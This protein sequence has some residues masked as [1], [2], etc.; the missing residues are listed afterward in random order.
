[1]LES[2]MDIREKS[3]VLRESYVFGTLGRIRTDICLSTADFKSAAATN[4]ATRVLN[5]KIIFGRNG[6]I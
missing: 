1:M 5:Y 2:Y 6:E 3:I 4:F